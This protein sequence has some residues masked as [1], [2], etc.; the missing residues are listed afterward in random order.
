[1]EDILP[2][3]LA[4]E[5]VFIGA[6]L[7]PIWVVFNALLGERNDVVKVFAT[8]ASYHLICEWSGLNNHFLENSHASNKRYGDLV[9]QHFRLRSNGGFAE[10]YRFLN[11]QY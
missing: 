6:T 11:H 10:D 5:A 1:M 2:A 9:Q 3:Q 8:G 7:V 4:A